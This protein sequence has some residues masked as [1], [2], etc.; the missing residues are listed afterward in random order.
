M[1]RRPNFIVA[2]VFLV[3]VSLAMIFAEKSAGCGKNPTITS[4]SYT[5]TVNGK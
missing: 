1:Q 2:V 3:L 4:K 5:L